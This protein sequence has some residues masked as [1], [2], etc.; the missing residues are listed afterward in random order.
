MEC[1]DNMS[2]QN[3]TQFDKTIDFLSV[4]AA[5][6][7]VYLHVNA[8]FWDFDPEARYWM[9]ANIIETVFYWAV[10]IF[11]MISGITL[12][13]SIERNGTKRFLR[14]RVI[15]VFFPYIFWS[16]L[17][18][19]YQSVVLEW[20]PVSEI[21]FSKIVNGL[22]NGNLVSVYW[23]FIPYFT[24]CITVPLFS[25]IS[26]ASRTYIFEYLAILGFLL[27]VLVVFICNTFFPAIKITQ[28]LPVAANYYLYF[29]IGY[30]FS[31]YNPNK[32][33]RIILYILGAIGFLMHLIPTYYLS[34]NANHIVDTFKGYYNLPCYL[35]SV[36]VFILIRQIY[37]CF[38]IRKNR[39]Q[40]AII[41]FFEWF[42]PYT[43]GIYLL[44]QLVLLG[45]LRFMDISQTSI[46][47]RIFGPWVIIFISIA[48]INLLRKIW[49][50]KPLLP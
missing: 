45:L 23:F 10:P 35:Q 1:S 2:K 17:G 36:A 13:P 8:C 47:W 9:T 18:I 44:H 50:F 41:K 5:I 28:L 6:A 49:I 48:L 21:S 43:F 31:D 29:I 42:R 25:N 33:I 39:I 40:L 7:V 46:W 26:R 14:N 22:I 16:I 30:L 4:S 12:I 24:I 15:K 34:V 38:E 20:F 32:R 37:Y 19:Y 11:F 27:N 3:L